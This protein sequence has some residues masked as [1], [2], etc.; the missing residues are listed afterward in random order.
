MF[1][2]AQKTLK[3]ARK[4]F[5][6]QNRVRLCYIELFLLV[7][8]TIGFIE[9]NAYYVPV[10]PIPEDLAGKLT[11]SDKFVVGFWNRF[12]I[13]VPVLIWFVLTLKYFWIARGLWQELEKNPNN[14]KSNHNGSQKSQ[15]NIGDS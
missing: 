9:L 8:I 5:G 3:V 1:K 6:T 2:K 14:L 12:L 11:A 10:I 7:L 15:G 4:C 13:L